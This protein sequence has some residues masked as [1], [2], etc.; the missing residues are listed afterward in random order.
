M[1]YFCYAMAVSGLL[2]ASPPT[3]RADENILLELNK[4]AQEGDSCRLHFLLNN[5][6]DA[7]F[8]SFRI[9]IAFF[10]RTGGFI[11]NATAD[12]LKVSPRKTIL[13]FFD[14]PTLQCAELGKVLL[15][16]AATCDAE[17]GL[18]ADCVEM[19]A[20]THRTEIR[21]YK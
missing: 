8:N 7:A 9:Q 20:P 12:F 16:D 10:D 5:E 6:T 18:V 4:V 1:R 15:N 3:A 21:F 2:L 13:R 11:N 19:I 17:D 14:V